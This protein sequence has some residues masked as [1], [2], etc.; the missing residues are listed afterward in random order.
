MTI[1]RDQL[2]TSIFITNLPKGDYDPVDLLEMLSNGCKIKESIQGEGFL[3]ICFESMEGKE[4]SIAFEGFEVEHDEE[5]FEIAI[6]DLKSEH[7]LKFPKQEEAA[8]K[9]N[10]E[11]TGDWTI[12]GDGKLP[13]NAEAEKEVP[14]QEETETVNDNDNTE[15]QIKF[16]LGKLSSR[17]HPENS[18][19]EDEE[20][21]KEEVNEQPEQE[22]K[23]DEK[24]VIIEQDIQG[25]SEQEVVEEKEDEKEE[26][27]SNSDKYSQIGSDQEVTEQPEPEK[28][29]EVATE[30]PPKQAEEHKKDST[31][32]FNIETP[33]ERQTTP[34][35]PE[36]VASTTTTT[37]KVTKVIEEGHQQ[38]KSAIRQIIKSSKPSQP[39]KATQ[40]TTPIIERVVN[41]HLNNETE[42]QT[43][44]RL[45][46]A[47]ILFVVFMN[48]M[49]L[50]FS[51]AD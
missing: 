9:V 14:V 33:R 36:I 31:L 41:Y 37:T 16:S 30:E 39:P 38:V 25:P 10:V 21:N 34:S 47:M 19:Q 43:V 28:V 13:S 4:N 35:K 20:D 1:T 8:P 18:E 26:E 44:I 48:F 24:E 32:L 40:S 29:E 15:E 42:K 50:F 27:V 51:R 2:P 12:L 49:R 45:L 23:E 7:L 11:D 6:E 5:S 22:E 46:Q 3:A 17:N